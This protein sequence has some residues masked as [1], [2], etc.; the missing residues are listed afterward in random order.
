MIQD[1]YN[2]D[3]LSPLITL[4]VSYSQQ[5]LLLVTGLHEN[6]FMVGEAFN[7]T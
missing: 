2:I 5:I 4:Q 7:H 1:M 6:D 3:C